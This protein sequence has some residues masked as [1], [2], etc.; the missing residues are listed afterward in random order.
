MEIFKASNQW[1]T[2]PADERFWT[3]TELR[4][5]CLEYRNN[6]VT[7]T[8]RYGDLR[9]EAQGRDMRLVGKTGASSQISHYAFGQL[10]SRVKSPAKYL[11]TLP[12]TLAAQNLNHGLKTQ[13][14]PDDKARML[15]HRNGDM[16]L[17]ATLTERY[18]RI[19]NHE[20]ADRL[21]EVLPEGWRLP[22]ARPA[23]SNDPR[24]RPATK[25]DLLNNRSSFLSVKEGD[26]IAPAGAY[27]SE[28]DMFLFMVNE[29][30]RINDGT[31]EGLSR[32]FMLWNS[33]VGD[34]VFGGMAGLYKTVCG[35]HIVWDA[36]DV[37]QFSIRH[38]GQA[39]AK[40]FRE[41]KVSIKKYNDSSAS[42]QEQKILWARDYEIA[43][44]KKEVIEE[45]LGFARKKRIKGIN[46]TSLSQAYDLAERH[47]DW[48]G[49][50]PNTAWGM[51]N[52]LTELSQLTKNADTR[53]QLDRA[54][55]KVME[56]A[57]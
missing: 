17:R 8:V 37:V 25:E 9:V 33:E 54:A 51:V 39:R 38:V 32:F 4:D 44:N 35:N 46:D 53:T 41:M 26:L 5:K 31:D 7:S 22:P 57:F 21:L 10:C 48:Y 28:K 47:E 20:I 34:K 42:E 55:G 16:L 6:A 2:R 43:G 15:F 11:R 13:R 45:L 49:T 56:I 27:A 36:K 18:E 12:P 14:E 24:A 3:L 23:F 29:D 50:T 1:A 52:G 19:W 30:K 40:A